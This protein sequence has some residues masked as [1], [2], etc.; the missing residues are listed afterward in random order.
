MT[1]P[2]VVGGVDDPTAHRTED[3]RGLRSGGSREVPV[4]PFV[5]R[6][7][8]WTWV[9]LRLRKHSSDSVPGESWVLQVVPRDPVRKRLAFW[10][11]TER[12]QT[13]GAYGPDSEGAWRPTTN[14]GEDRVLTTRPGRPR[15]SGTGAGSFGAPVPWSDR[16]GGCE[17]RCVR[18]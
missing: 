3:R 14:L 16:N 10:D 12:V 4:R 11:G 6:D 15:R 18:E 1:A 17:N 2:D 9:S 5:V 7:R 13:V 8:T